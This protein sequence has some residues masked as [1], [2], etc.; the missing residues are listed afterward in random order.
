VTD[1]LGKRPTQPLKRLATI[2]ISTQLSAER[3]LLVSQRQRGQR[4]VGD[5]RLARIKVQS[6]NLA[7]S[8]R[9]TG[10]IPTVLVDVCWDVSN[11]D[12]IDRH[13]AS[14]ISP[15]RPDT[16]WTRYTVANYHWAAH[17]N[18]GWRVAAGEDLRQAPCA[19]D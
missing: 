19:L 1:T 7:D 3:A 12:V 15:S 14:I 18:D 17:R 13:G 8:N 10:E 2:A 5:T 16:G 6:V 9:S 11:V 4:Q